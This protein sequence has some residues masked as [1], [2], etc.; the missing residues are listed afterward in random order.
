MIVSTQQEV[1]STVV[2]RTHVYLDLIKTIGH[3]LQSEVVIINAVDRTK[4]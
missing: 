2:A 4:V 1:A 3:I